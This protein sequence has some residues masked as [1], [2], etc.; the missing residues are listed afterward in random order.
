MLL[1]LLGVDLIPRGYS[2]VRWPIPPVGDNRIYRNRVAAVGFGPLADRGMGEPSM[3]SN[4]GVVV[5]VEGRNLV[6]AASGRLGCSF[7][8]CFGQGMDQPVVERTA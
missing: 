2:E 3:S 4:L 8:L 6:E 7:A 1:L 5:V